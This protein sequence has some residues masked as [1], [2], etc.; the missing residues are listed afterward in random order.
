MILQ[1]SQASNL[2][3]IDI[4]YAFYVVIYLLNVLKHL[5]VQ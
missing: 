1:L 4:D 5:H 3:T 2:I